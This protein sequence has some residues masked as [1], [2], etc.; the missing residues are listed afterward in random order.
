MNAFIDELRTNLKTVSKNKKLT[1][2]LGNESCDLD[3]AVCSI[4]FAYFQNVCST[5]KSGE[6]YLPVFNIPRE[7]LPLK[8]EVSF[9]LKKYGVKDENVICRDEL[10]F[11]FLRENSE[12]SIVLV[13]HHILSDS[14]KNMTSFVSTIL[15][16]RPKDEASWTYKGNVEVTIEPVGSCASLVC[17][18][19]IKSAI[20]VQFLSDNTDVA[21]LLYGTII[22]D[23]ANFLPSADRARP[24][25][26]KMADK[27]ENILNIKD[28]KENYKSI[29]F[30]EILTA[31]IDCSSLN[32]LQL[33]SRDLKI[34]KGLPLPGLPMLAKDF[35]KRD[36][37][38]LAIS[39]FCEK[40]KT[41]TILIIGLIVVDNAVTRDLAVCS[42][43]E[44]QL[45]KKVIDA[46][47]EA[48]EPSFELEKSEEAL[49][50]CDHF[51]QH[52]IKVSRKQIV[53]IIKK[54]LTQ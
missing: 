27:L 39:K 34:I 7:E 12:F 45:H 6:I 18:E 15:D 32:S 22:L 10:D 14:M 41:T 30:N 16:H 51:E 29:V 21:N 26:F 36:D 31:R 33:L 43:E 24:L 50:F 44:C 37:C 49:S 38:A 9:V 53:P 46:L 20:G 25:D 11:K 23:T 3:S 13:D 17:A 52:N 47:L 40:N 5:N 42:I 8:T 35:L 28:D 48:N 19:I 2:V 54:M 1:L 4:V